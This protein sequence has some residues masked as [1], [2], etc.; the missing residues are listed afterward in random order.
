MK[1]EDILKVLQ[2][3]DSAL[4]NHSDAKIIHYAKLSARERTESERKKLS[5]ASRG[6]KMPEHAIEK[7]RRANKNRVITDEHKAKISETLSG[8]KLPKKTC[9]K[10]SESRTGMK[11]SKS[12]IKKL[13]KAA[14][15]RCVPV[16]QFTLDG[17]WI[18]DFIGLSE[19]GHSIGK[20]NGRS[21]QLVC[22]YYRDN[23]TKGSKQCGGY[24]WKYKE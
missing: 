19:A 11:H 3:A 1:K 2:Q 8:R 17:V 6:R 21:I 22:N 16:S 18:R 7:I 23:L 13:E 10:M 12:T 15:K 4:G 14:Q 24:I 5:K 9:N 20:E